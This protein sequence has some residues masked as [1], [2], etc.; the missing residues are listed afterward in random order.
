MQEHSKAVHFTMSDAV[1]R[2]L[3]RMHI[4]QKRTGMRGARKGHHYVD[5]IA[6]GTKVTLRAKHVVEPFTSFAA[7]RNIPAMGSFTEVA[8]AF[9]SKSRFGRYCS[10]GEGITFTGYRHPIEASSSSSAFFNEEREMFHS[11]ADTVEARGEPRPVRNPT[12]H[13]PQPGRG[14][15][16]IGNDVWIGDGAT[17]T[18]GISIG[19][20]AVIAAKSIVTKDVPAYAVVGG[21][22]ARVLKWRFS[23]EIQQGLQESRWWDYE[24][25]DLLKLP[26]GDPEALLTTLAQQS[27]NLRR[28]TPDQTPLW[29]KIQAVLQ[30]YS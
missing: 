23:E 29:E 18:G 6:P 5:R 25:A 8:S 24:H 28:Y 7:G 11:Y 13:A 10:V 3:E 12:I 4:F 14:W 27:G 17:L 2:L 26:M 21:A 1:H 9:P 30:G 16:D 20:G 15:I 22:P 19:D